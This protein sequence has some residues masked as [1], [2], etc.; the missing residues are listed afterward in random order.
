M[1]DPLRPSATISD[2]E[3]VQAIAD[4]REPM[5]GGGFHWVTV[6]DLAERLDIHPNRVRSKA[7]RAAKRGLS[8]GCI[9]GCRGD[10]ELLPAGEA[11]LADP[12]STELGE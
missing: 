8:D 5:P 4:L 6:W 7:R 9:C 1:N 12:S 2:R 10:F 3:W 11:L